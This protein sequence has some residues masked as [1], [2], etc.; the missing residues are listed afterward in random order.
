MCVL[1]H[2]NNKTKQKKSEEKKSQLLPHHQ[3]K[4]NFGRILLLGNKEE[5]C[6]TEHYAQHKV[7]AV[8][9][10]KNRSETMT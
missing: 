8:R 6:V 9:L 7:Q 4:V 2:P 3:Q 10:H 5:R 1:I